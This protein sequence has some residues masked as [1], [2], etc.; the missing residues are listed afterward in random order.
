M[1]E[2]IK[3]TR[4]AVLGFG[5]GASLALSPY[6]WAQNP[7][8]IE[9][10]PAGQAA[11]PPQSFAPLVKRVSPAVVNVSATEKTE[12]SGGTALSEQLPDALRGTP[13]DEFLRR[14][15]EQ[16]GGAQQGERG[17]GQGLRPFS[18]NPDDD[19]AGIKR[20]ALGS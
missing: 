17:G 6:V 16:R 2:W 10:A 9:P 18:D 11:A 8:P 12:K 5:L 3:K 4:A 1:T 14:F 15:F 19:G 7:P 13:F 20:I